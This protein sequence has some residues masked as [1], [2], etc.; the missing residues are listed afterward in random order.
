MKKTRFFILPGL[1]CL[2][3]TSTILAGTARIVGGELAPFEERP[4]Q[5]SLQDSS[6]QD[7]RARHQCGGAL[8]GDRWVLTA[9][10]C[11][12]HDQVNIDRVLV[13]T[14]TLYNGGTELSVRNMFVHPEPDADIALIELT[15]TAPAHIPRLQLPDDGVLQVAASSGDWATVSGWGATLDST[16]DGGGGATNYLRQVDVPL[17]SNT[18]C[19]AAYGDIISDHEICAGLPE[20]GIDSCWGDSGGPLTVE[21]HGNDYS[22]G[23]VSWG[24]GC[25]EPNAYG[26]YARTS[27][28][29]DWI[30]NTMNTPSRG[31]DCEW[32]LQ[33]SI[34]GRRFNYMHGAFVWDKVSIYEPAGQCGAIRKKTYHVFS[35][36]M[37]SAPVFD[38]EYSPRGEECRWELS[39]ER[40]IDGELT[41]S[42]ISQNTTCYHISKVQ[43]EGGAPTFHV[44]AVD[45]R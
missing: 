22:V 39:Q 30:D 16:V 25:A 42:W 24:A 9:A 3:S 38:T 36:G 7:T 44:E 1:L 37:E 15:R 21:V 4:Y 11:L 29:L 20:G 19:R 12:T 45:L 41:R 5:V 17:V 18:E 8:I 27:S 40:L 6:F 31:L 10:H 35:G 28:F 33:R 26:V 14:D 43:K 2:A 23:V 32:V 34:D 13:G